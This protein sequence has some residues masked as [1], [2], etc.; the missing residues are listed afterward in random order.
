MTD[1]KLNAD[2]MDDLSRMFMALVQEVWI[3]RDRVAVMEELLTEKGQLSA[4]AIDDFEASAEFTQRVEAMRD[5]FA[6]RIIGAP[7]AAV[8]RDVDQ[9]LARAS[10]ERPTV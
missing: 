6:A 4:E 8:E 7:I 1:S 2:N 3:L 10:L 9:I 5:R